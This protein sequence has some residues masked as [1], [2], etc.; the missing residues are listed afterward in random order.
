M[1]FCCYNCGTSPR[2]DITRKAMCV[3]PD[4]KARSH[5]D[6][7]RG[8]Y[9]I[10]RMCGFLPSLTTVQSACAIL[11]CHLRPVW[12]YHIFINSI[13]NGR[14][15]SKKYLIQNICSNFKL[16]SETCLILIKTRRNIIINV[17]SLLVKCPLFLSYF[18]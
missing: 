1:T 16:F 10:L 15:F 18:N 8:R 5:A 12:F 13:I 6:C 3:E 2:C 17:H 4:I 7:C 14:I 9:E 11:H